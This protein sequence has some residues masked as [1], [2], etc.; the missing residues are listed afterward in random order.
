[1]GNFGDG[2]IDRLIALHPE[3]KLCEE[4]ESNLIGCLQ[5]VESGSL[6]RSLQGHSII[7]SPAKENCGLWFVAPFTST[8]GDLARAS[9]ES[10]QHF[11]YNIYFTCP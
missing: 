1:V 8:V 9:L 4:V 3:S 6:A 7:I 11:R 2:F 5:Y 10:V